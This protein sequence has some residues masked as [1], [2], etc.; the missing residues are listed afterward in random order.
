MKSFKQLIAEVAQPKSDDEL[1]F[2][3][4][5]LVQIIKHPVADYKQHTGDIDGNGVQDKRKKHKRHAD[6]S[7]KEDEIVYEAKLDPVGQEDDDIDND[8]DVD[9]SD[10][11]LHNRRKSIKRAIGKISQTESSELEEKAV[12]Q[13]Q[14]KAAA[15]ALAVKR[16]KLPKSALQGAS[17]E[18]FGMSTKDLEDFAKTKLGGLP[19]KVYEDLD[20][21]IELD[22]AMKLDRVNIVHHDS[23]S[24]K[25]AKEYVKGHKGNYAPG[26]PSEKH[27]K[28]SEKFHTTYKRVDGKSGFA[29]SGHDIYQHNTT[30]EKFHVERSPNG[31][32][33]YGTDHHIRKINEEVE[34]DEEV[35]NKILKRV[36]DDFQM[37]KNLSTSDVLRKH[38]ATKKIHTNY[39]AQD[40]GG[41]LAMVSD[42]LRQSHGDKHV[43]H[44]FGMSKSAVQKLAEEVELDEISASTLR[45]YVNKAK[46]DKARQQKARTVAKSDTKKYGLASDKERA[47]AAHRKVGQRGTGISIAQKKLG[48]YPKDRAQP[49]VMAREEIELDE[50]IAGLFK[51]ASE[52]EKSAK[53]RGLV[54]KPATHPSGEATKYHIAKDQQGNNRGH[55][56]HGTKTGRLKEAVELDEISDELKKRYHEKGRE[57]VYNRFTGRG[58]YEKPKDPAHYTPT[59]RVKKGVLD[60]PEAIKYR[61]KIAS[62][63]KYLAKVADQLK[64]EEVDLTENFKAGSVKLNDGSSVIVKKQ[65]ADL[66]NQM[67]GDLNSNNKKKMMDVAMK[68]KAG[69]AEILGFA[70]EA[71]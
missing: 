58:K 42:L 52:W 30:G 44:Y 18:M 10:S 11:Y 40:A 27:E 1:E 68:D 59:G 69:F 9:N 12:S 14:Q 37:Y 32:G 65:D 45:S 17:K 33:F 28:D 49:K 48:M 62:R 5:H 19:L 66:L 31:K 25:F 46:E 43:T 39:S 36:H 24:E 20:E 29:G 7:D 63:N 16:G 2:K 26:G 8:G 22:E 34:L 41:K 4:K 57:D 67:F 35:N 56:D 6:Y 70:R 23:A 60:R 15:V 55:F 3:D 47:D 64:K 61:E 51:D 21:E 13:S 54:V 50:N 53:A 38:K 71:L